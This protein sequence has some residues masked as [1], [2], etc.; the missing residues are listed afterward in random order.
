MFRKFSTSLSRKALFGNP[1]LSSPK[2]LQRFTNETLVHA[3][4]L[5]SHLLTNSDNV[6]YIRDLDRLSDMLCRVIDLCEF[7]RVAH[8]NSSFVKVAEDSHNIMFEYMN[9]LNTSFG[10]FKRLDDIVKN[11]QIW[12]SLSDE[13]KSVGKLLHLDFLKS[14][15]N[16]NDETKNKFIE[17]SSYIALIGQEFNNGVNEPKETQIVIPRGNW[18]DNDIPSDYKKYVS[19]SWDGSLKIPIYGSTPFG[20]LSTTPNRTIRKLIWSGLHSVPDSQLQLLQSMLKG[21]SA[22]SMIMGSDNYAEY[23]LMD[24]MAESSENVMKFLMQLKQKLEP[25]VKLEIEK[26]TSFDP[27]LSQLDPIQIKPWD[28]DYLIANYL[29]KQKSQNIVDLSKYFSLNTVMNG[30]S[31]LFYSIYGIKFKNVELNE[32]DTWHKDVKKIEAIDKNG[33][34]IGN[35]YLDLYHR[36]N[37]TSHP[38]HFTVVCSR[39][40]A[41]VEL[42]DQFSWSEKSVET[43]SQSNG[44]IYQLPSICL[45]CNYSPDLN[46]GETFLSIDQIGTLFHE[47]GHAMHSLLGRT[48]L[49]NVSGTRCV[50]DFVE[51]PSILNET[52]AKDI[53]VLCWMGKHYKTGE[54]VEIHKSALEQHLRNEA[55]LKYTESYSQVKMALLDQLVH[56]NAPVDGSPNEI[57][58]MYHQLERKTYFADDISNWPGKFGHLFT[59]GSLYYSYLLDRSLADHVWDKLF[60][61]DPW[62]RKG[63][64]KF[65]MEVLEWGGSRD[66]W[67]CV[68]KVV[69]DNL[70]MEKL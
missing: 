63:G 52:F 20:I 29:S 13:E 67:K 15:I 54:S 16:M 19:K 39:Q 45:V 27:Q 62:C 14:G 36:L 38:A 23:S 17:L 49:H 55:L 50:T 10:L 60:E 59:Y 5:T 30:L 37:K 11:E 32:E 31:N 66:A 2:G 18:K 22:L 68:D 40:I 53:R 70:S 51:L 3:K 25:K 12:N 33:Q 46:T 48:K 7:I 21:R 34:K 1:Y 6:S 47:M 58:E 56:S 65:R 9:V 61:K 41:P 57:V 8:P 26:L 44:D 69:G 43:I 35:L 24:K 64:E 42:T 4:A 28:R